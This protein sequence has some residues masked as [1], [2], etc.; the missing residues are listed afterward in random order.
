MSDTL[1]RDLRAGYR[2]DEYADMSIFD[3]V[4]LLPCRRGYREESLQGRE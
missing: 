4:Y 3:K 2:D 1:V